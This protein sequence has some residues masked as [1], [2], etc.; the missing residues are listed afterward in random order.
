LALQIGSLPRKRL[1]NHACDSLGYYWRKVWRAHG[2]SMKNKLLPILVLAGIAT[3]ALA[4]AADAQRGYDLVVSRGRVIDPES[5]LDAVRDIGIRDGRIVEISATVLKGRKIDARGLVVAPGFI[6]LHAHGQYPGAQRIQA[7]DGV[8]TT[9]DMESGHWPVSEHYRRREGKML[10]NWGVATSHGCARL[11]VVTGNACPDR[12]EGDHTGRVMTREVTHEALAPEAL[13][14]LL[15]AIRSDIDAGALGIGL[16]ID[17]VPGASRAEVY[18]IFKVAAEQGVPVHV[19]LRRRALDVAKGI[20]V[21]VAQEVIA[22]AVLTGSALQILHITSTALPGDVPVLLDMISRANQRGFDITTEVYPYTAA[23]TSIGAA[24][25]DDGWRER[26]GIDY[27]DLQWAA[28]GER[29]TAETFQRYRKENPRG[30][31]IIHAI[32]EDDVRAALANPY[33]SIAS[34]GMWWVTKGEHPRGAGTF[35][36]VLGRYVREQQVLSLQDAIAK[37]TIM[38]ARRLERVSSMMRRKGRINIGADADLVIFDPDT[39]IDNATFEEP[40]RTSTGVR[41]LLVNGV[42]VVR[43]GRLVEGAAPGRAIKR[44]VTP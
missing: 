8:T 26:A 11:Q 29:L 42:P 12:I 9:I 7:L 40:M 37:M 23:S 35:A 4:S 41:H 10:L 15:D 13:V 27:G 34:D 44:D 16:G 30:N 21:A 6:D 36:R 2:R 32:A 43:D 22:N 25:F 19:H 1:V 31:V 28:T 20:G 5:Q 24:L 33:V 39:I 18:E 38:P 17:Y 3:G 14:A